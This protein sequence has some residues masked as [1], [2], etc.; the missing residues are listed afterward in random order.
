MKIFSI[1]VVFDK[2]FHLYILCLSLLL[3][4]KIKLSW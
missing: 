4:L 2:T 3:Y 1:Y